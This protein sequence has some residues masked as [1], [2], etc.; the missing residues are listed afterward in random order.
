MKEDA[1]GMEIKS[2]TESSNVL[3]QITR[4]SLKMNNLNFEDK[5]VGGRGLLRAMIS[6]FRPNYFKISVRYLSK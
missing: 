6:D 3:T 4:C 2:A 5:E 1:R